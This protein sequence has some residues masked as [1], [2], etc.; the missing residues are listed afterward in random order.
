MSNALEKKVDKI[1]DYLA[2]MTRD[3]N[4]R[5]DAIDK[6]LDAIDE[7]LGTLK[8]T[9]RRIEERQALVE[10]SNGILQEADRGRQDDIRQLDIRLSRIEDQLRST[11]APH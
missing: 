11:P 6:R 4:Q 8:G 5:F 7:D 1:L 10:K 2:V 9:T 3:N